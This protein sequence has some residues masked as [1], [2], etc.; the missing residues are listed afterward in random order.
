MVPR[1]PPSAL[2]TALLATTLLATGCTVGPD[3]MRPKPP[4]TASYTPTPLATLPK[5]GGETQQRLVPGDD[6]APEWWKNFNSPELD[7]V[8]ALAIA[9]SPTLEASRHTLAQARETIVANQGAL[10]PQAD[11]SAE[12]S[13]S[14]ARGGSGRNG[15][16][17]NAYSI[18]PFVSFDTDVFGGLKRQVE[19]VTALAEFQRYELGAAYLTL[20]GNVITQVLNIASIR[21]QIAEVNGLIALDRRNLDLTNASFQGGRSARTDVLSAESQLTS[22]LTQLPPLNQQLA[23]AR[24]ALAVLVGHPPSEWT[25]PDFDLDRLAAPETLPVTVPS[26]LV[27]KRPDILAAEATLHASSAAVGVATANLYP[28]L[29]LSAAWSTGAAAPSALFNPASVIW[30]IAANLAQP[31]FHGGTLT[32]QRRAA[33]EQFNADLADYRD[34]VLVSF[35]QVADVLRALEHDAQ[36]LDAQRTAMNTA[37]DSLNLV[38]ESYRVG[39]ASLLQVLDAQRLLFQARLGFVRAKAQR[40]QDT[41]QLYVAMGG[42]WTG[43]APAA[44]KEIGIFSGI[45]GP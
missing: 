43:Y 37:Q 23:V 14:K 35:G 5:A 38:E 27:R 4:A 16:I 33:V 2:R 7:A 25:P 24:H 21:A 3:F 40:L 18:G 10:L 15:V 22:D 19:E 31:L 30:S 9:D 8:V 29:S 17:A 12:V 26:E 32:A 28:N 42:A 39:Q 34:T 36:L 11:L 6:V 45:R 44:P 1:N 13:R 20:T 41:S